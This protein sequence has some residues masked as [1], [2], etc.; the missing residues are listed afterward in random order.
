LP[1]VDPRG[2]ASVRFPAVMP[3]LF[4]ITAIFVSAMLCSAA[5]PQLPAPV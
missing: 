3:F 4:R 1:S 2:M 5:R